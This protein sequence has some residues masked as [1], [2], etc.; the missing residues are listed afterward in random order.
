MDFN[1]TNNQKKLKGGKKMKRYF[2][3]A[4]L[5]FAT[6]AFSNSSYASPISWE[7]SPD[8]NALAFGNTVVLGLNEVN[9]GEGDTQPSGIFGAGF[10]MTGTSAGVLFDADLY[11]WD[12]YNEDTGTGTGYWDSFIVMVSTDGYYWDLLNTDPIANSESTFVWGGTAF[13]DGIKDSYVTAPGGDDLVLL[14]SMV[15]TTFYISL[16][17]DTITDPD[18]DTSYPSWGSL[19]V[20]PVPE[21]GTMILLGSGLVGLAFYGRRRKKA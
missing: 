16:V 10:T 11:S 8:G 3:F 17:L 12:S 7:Y 20:Q 15:P 21:P 2:V 1:K 6:L 18:S 5:L 14:T 9:S 19:H 4:L 13:D